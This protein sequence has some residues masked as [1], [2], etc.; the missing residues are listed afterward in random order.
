MTTTLKL[1]YV[2]GNG[3]I[4][5]KKPDGDYTLINPGDNCDLNIHAGD[6]QQVVTIKETHFAR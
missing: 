1:I 2:S 5:V 4:E 6:D 3:A